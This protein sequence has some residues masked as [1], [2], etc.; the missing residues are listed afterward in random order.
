MEKKA[1]TE[2][3]KDKC[4][5]EKDYGRW[6]ILKGILVTLFIFYIFAV[7]IADLSADFASIYYLVL[8]II[9]AIA[10]IS[11][12]V[13]LVEYIMGRDKLPK[14]IS[15]LIVGIIVAIVAFIVASIFVMINKHN[16]IPIVV[17]IAFF[18]VALIMAVVKVIWEYAQDPPK[19]N[20]NEEVCAQKGLCNLDAWEAYKQA[21]NLYHQRFNFFLVAESMLVVSFAT[22]F[23]SGYL[24]TNPLRI[25]ITI[26]GMIFTLSWFYV[27]NGIGYRMIYLREEYLMRCNQTFKKYFESVEELTIPSSFFM[28]DLLPAATFAFWCYLFYYTIVFW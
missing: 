26:L 23:S 17:L 27:N 4:H 18:V 12:F 21:D 11:A 5:P 25:A 24:N 28:T 22:T 6:T 2:K 13:L 19:S 16:H 1:K 10:I 20:S 7:L 9:A 15:I 8:I 14:T 3:D